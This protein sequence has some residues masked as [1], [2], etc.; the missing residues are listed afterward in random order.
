M[1]LL[2]RLCELLKETGLTPYI[3]KQGCDMKDCN[4]SPKK[5]NEGERIRLRTEGKLDD[6]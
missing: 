5:D 2:D 4:C 3:H 6:Q 1:S